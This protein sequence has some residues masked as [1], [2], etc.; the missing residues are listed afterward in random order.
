MVALAC[1]IRFDRPGSILFE[2][3]R[4]DLFN[5]YRNFVFW[6]RSRDESERT[7]SVAPLARVG[8]FL[9]LTSL[10]DLPRLFNMLRDD[11]AL[12]NERCLIPQRRRNLTPDWCNQ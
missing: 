11:F 3:N 8:A 1:V 7:R 4:P 2:C 10:E 5:S 9:Y 6:L 12:F